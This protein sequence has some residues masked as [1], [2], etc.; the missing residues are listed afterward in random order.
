MSRSSDLRNLQSRAEAVLGGG[1]GTKPPPPH[2][3]A[4][5]WQGTHQNVASQG[6]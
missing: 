6:I 5:S 1:H 3:T 4:M 2:Q